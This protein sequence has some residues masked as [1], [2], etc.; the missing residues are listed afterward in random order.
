MLVF[1]EKTQKIPSR[2][3]MICNWI[4]CPCRTSKVFWKACNETSYIQ[5]HD[6]FIISS[7]LMF[8]TKSHYCWPHSNYRC[9]P[10]DRTFLFSSV[11]TVECYQCF[12]IMLFQNNR[13]TCSSSLFSSLLPTCQLYGYPLVY[14][15][16]VTANTSSHWIK[17][18][19]IRV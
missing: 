9:Y 18:N 7:S 3:I 4:K 8:Q 6:L 2:A 12:C 13:R 14:S 17:Q 16:K 15:L 10:S 1:Q 19:E 11:V 5:P